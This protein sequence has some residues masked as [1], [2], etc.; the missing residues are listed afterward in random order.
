MADGV[1]Y[2]S[3]GSRVQWAP[4][5]AASRR[6]PSP[7]PG[8]RSA[9]GAPPPPAA[10]LLAPAAALPEPRSA[11]LLAPRWQVHL[12]RLAAL[13][14]P[15]VAMHALPVAPTAAAMCTESALRTAF[16]LGNPSIG[17]FMYDKYPADVHSVLSMSAPPAVPGPAASRGRRSP[18]AAPPSPCASPARLRA[19][20]G[21]QPLRRAERRR[22]RLRHQLHCVHDR[23]QLPG[24]CLARLGLRPVQ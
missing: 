24:P 16:Q 8:R 23:G 6:R 4:L 20:L 10:L 22:R 14:L 7:P 18:H 5:G 17:L 3:T 9:W 21:W 19:R 12:Q 15:A 11:A 2:D 13:H 1:I